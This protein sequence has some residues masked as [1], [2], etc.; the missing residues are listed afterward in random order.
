[1]LIRSPAETTWPP[2]LDPGT[3]QSFSGAPFVIYKIGCTCSYP[4]AILEHFLP[5]SSHPTTALL[6][7]FFSL[8]IV[9]ATII[10][11]MVF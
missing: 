7:S 11:I 9:V 6:L 2:A 5:N 4:G 8:Y 10:I 1:M 3:T